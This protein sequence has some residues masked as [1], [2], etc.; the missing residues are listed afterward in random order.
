[1][2]LYYKRKYGADPPSSDLSSDFDEH[3]SDDEEEED[4]ISGALFKLSRAGRDPPGGHQHTLSF[5]GSDVVEGIVD[6]EYDASTAATSV[7]GLARLSVSEATD[8][9]SVARDTKVVR[10]VHF[11]SVEV[12]EQSYTDDGGSLS[13]PST[14]MSSVDDYESIRGPQ[15]LPKF[16]SMALRLRQAEGINLLHSPH[17]DSEDPR[18]DERS[19]S[20]SE[21]EEDE[22]Y[23]LKVV[24]LVQDSSKQETVNSNGRQ[25]GTETVAETEHAAQGRK[26]RGGLRKVFRKMKT[27]KKSLTL[28]G[29]M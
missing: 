29:D 6:D 3:E 1:M 2:D 5:T 24:G 12:R 15:R 9:S 16:H 11:D 8:N 26:A 14:T 25:V 28:L 10:S 18:E 22:R 20:S 19:S 7:P 17:I 27:N 21:E 4:R 13:E 23:Q